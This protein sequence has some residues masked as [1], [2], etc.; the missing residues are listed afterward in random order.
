MGIENEN[1]LRRNGMASPARPECIQDDGEV[2]GL[3]NQRASS[4][5]E[6][7][8]R[9][10]D[11]ADRAQA[12]PYDDGLAGDVHRATTH[13]HCVHDAREIVNENDHVGGFGRDSSAVSCQRDA[14]RRRTERG[15]VVRAVADHHDR[16]AAPHEVAHDRN[17][18]FW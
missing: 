7:P 9:R 11:H 8:N 14:D 6:Q 2:D 10:G 18:V 13:S 15:S 5:R 12:K 4:W 17:L 16:L 1:L 3:L